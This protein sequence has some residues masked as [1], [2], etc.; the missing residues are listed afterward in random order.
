LTKAPRVSSAIQP[1]WRL[2]LRHTER[3]C[4]NLETTSD[5]EKTLT[6]SE[7]FCCVFNRLVRSPI[8]KAARGMRCVRRMN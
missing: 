5:S 3:N 7:T 2:R 6:S 4:A 1:N 8:A